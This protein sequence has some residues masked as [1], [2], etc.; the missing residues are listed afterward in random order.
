VHR[1]ARTL[2]LG[3]VDLLARGAN[4]LAGAAAA[5]EPLPGRSCP[6]AE[7]PLPISGYPFYLAGLTIGTP[8]ADHGSHGGLKAATRASG[9]ATGRDLLEVAHYAAFRLVSSRIDRSRLRLLGTEIG[10]RDIAFRPWGFV[11]RGADGALVAEGRVA[12]VATDGFLLAATLYNRGTTPIAFT[13]VFEVLD[14]EDPIH[15]GMHPFHLAPRPHAAA[16]F[17]RLANV[18]RVE[19]R[20]ASGISFFDFAGLAYHRAIR[21][22]FRGVALDVA[23]GRPSRA[24]LR[25]EEMGLGPGAR[26]ELLLHLGVGETADEAEAALARALATETRRQFAVASAAALAAR[27]GETE[28]APPREG[29]TEEAEPT[30]PPEPE[31]PLPPLVRPTD[32]VESDWEAFLASLPAPHADGP[33]ARRLLELAATGLR[34]NV[35]APRGRLARRASC[36]AKVHF[37]G[38]W[39]WDSAYGALGA[40][41]FD[42]ALAKDFLASLFAAQR[43]DGH[44]A[45]AVDAATFAT[46]S[47]LVADLTMPPAQGFALAAVARRDPTRDRAWLEEMYE[48][49]RAYVAWFERHRRIPEGGLFRYENAIESGW[50]DT[51]R[52]PNPRVPAVRA[53]KLDLGGLSGLR[54][55]PPGLAA[56]DLC[57][58]L[59]AYHGWLAETARALGRP[60]GEAES[61]RAR[62]AAIAERVDALLWDEETGAYL[63]R[64]LGR[65]GAPDQ[66]FV[67]TLT[68]VVVWPLFLGLCRDAGRARRLIETHVLDPAKLMGDPDDPLAPRYPVP[69]VAYGDPAYDRARGGFY[70]RG[71]VWMIPTYATLVALFRY[72]YEKEAAALKARILTLLATACEGGLFETYDASTGEIGLGSASLSGPGEPAAFQIGLTTALALEVL[73]DRHERDRFL[74][75]GEKGFTGFVAEARTLEDGALFYR[76]EPACGDDVPRTRLER[77]ADGSVS[78]L[79]DDPFGNYDLATARVSLPTLGVGVAKPVEVRLGEPVV[80]GPDG[81]VGAAEAHASAGT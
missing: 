38:M 8:I 65:R 80:V 58:W 45:Y 31:P 29:T 39:G 53:M 79:L 9:G 40:S 32:E 15:E 17:D 55:A 44:I 18:L 78:L 51:P 30:S 48:R 5:P 64:D 20:R 62:A 59:H 7:C 22:S 27:E 43:Q 12:T 47:P 37:T 52:I 71:Q 14:D 57:A 16:R 42:P 67:R 50:D 63:D 72:G 75:P 3:A 70:W 73:L 26:L 56:L 60:E 4:A 1:A 61:H 46:V 77:R 6:R 13:P 41:E 34:M 69:S 49:S 19:Y 33:E 35:Y 2:I 11:E 54:T 36:P 25:G 74:L 81:K 68:P 66:G 28:P 76:V 23:P 21:P 10:R 24:A